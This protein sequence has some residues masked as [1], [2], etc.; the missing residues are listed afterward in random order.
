MFDTYQALQP[1]GALCRPTGGRRRGYPSMEWEEETSVN[2]YTRICHNQPFVRWRR[3]EM[4][5]NIKTRR[6]VVALDSPFPTHLRKTSVLWRFFRILLYA[7]FLLCH[8]NIFLC[9]VSAHGTAWSVPIRFVFWGV[10][11][12]PHHTGKSLFVCQGVLKRTD[13]Y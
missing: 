3:K 9:V 12:G 4:G 13:L 7:N 5:R 1:E 6:K 8:A 10:S 11:I 2:S